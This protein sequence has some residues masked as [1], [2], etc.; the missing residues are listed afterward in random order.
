MVCIHQ[1]KSGLHWGR[2]PP[3]L[4]GPKQQK[5]ISYSD[6]IHSRLFLLLT[7]ILFHPV[8]LPSLQRPPPLPLKRIRGP[9]NYAMKQDF[10]LPQPGL[11][12]VASAHI[13]LARISHVVL[14]STGSHPLK[15]ENCNRV[16]WV[17]GIFFYH[18]LQK[19]RRKKN[20][21]IWKFRY[22]LI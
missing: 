11:S 7:C 9:E 8:I 10:S 20:L 2:I 4:S 5:F 18:R 3:K 15:K 21:S 17:C 16:A 19:Q 13:S 12:H 14:G 6:K 1:L 22:L